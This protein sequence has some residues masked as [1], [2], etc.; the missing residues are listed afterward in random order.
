MTAPLYFAYNH[1]TGLFFI[2]NAMNKFLALVLSLPLLLSVCG[3][4]SAPSTS[5]PTP[6][7]PP[8]SNIR[9]I[10]DGIITVKASE[11]YDIKFTVD[12]AAMRNPRI[13]GVFQATGGTGNDIEALIMDDAS[14]PKWTNGHN[15]TGIYYSGKLSASSIN[16]TISNPGIYHLIFDNSFSL[17]TPKEITAKV[18][19]YW[20]L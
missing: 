14:F 8:G 7:P 15:V 16:I 5:V 18:D 3:C 9:N 11:Y 19:L 20:G 10:V 4:N 12:A 13:V 2:K 6:S 17:I 1:L